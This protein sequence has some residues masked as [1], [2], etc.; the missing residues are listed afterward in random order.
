MENSAPI[1][2]L[3]K[4]HIQTQ[5]NRKVQAVGC[6]WIPVQDAG[7]WRIKI[8]EN[9]RLMYS[10]SC[11]PMG[12]NLSSLTRVQSAAYPNQRHVKLIAMR[13]FPLHYRQ[14]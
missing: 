10:T 6:D 4:C 3:G 1:M 8:D 9:D 14:I 13:W 5:R 11:R 12:T 7:L 2:T